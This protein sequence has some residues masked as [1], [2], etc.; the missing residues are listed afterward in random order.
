MTF[1]AG[2]N[3]QG[4]A[5]SRSSRSECES[6][7]RGGGGEGFGMTGSTC[8]FGSRC[9]CPVLQQDATRWSLFFSPYPA[10]PTYSSTFFWKGCDGTLY[11]EVKGKKYSGKS[12]LCFPEVKR[13]RS[14][15]ASKRFTALWEGGDQPVHT[16]G[17]AAGGSLI[18]RECA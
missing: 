2:N 5:R 6:D 17:E 7:P 12:Q 18:V 16:G 10:P 13:R 8:R 11:Q 14:L 4:A 9:L 1:V 15:V 3:T